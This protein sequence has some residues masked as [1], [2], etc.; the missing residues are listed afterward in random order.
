MG[1]SRNLHVRLYKNLIPMRSQH[2]NFFS[3]KNKNKHFGTYKTVRTYFDYQSIQDATTR[4]CA[5]VRDFFFFLKSVVCSR[6]MWFQ[7]A[8]AKCVLLKITWHIQDVSCYNN[9]QSQEMRKS[10]YLPTCVS[11]W[12]T[13]QASLP[14]LIDHLSCFVT[15]N[16]YFSRMH[17][18]A[19]HWG[20]CFLN[21]IGTFAE[22]SLSPA[23]IC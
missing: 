3:N 10:S 15:T 12:C 5:A 2:G 4:F 6:S 8:S 13:K 23:R 19:E 20:A 22:R 16:Y 18:A 14:F 21:K 1:T 17:L 7:C 11:S 9:C